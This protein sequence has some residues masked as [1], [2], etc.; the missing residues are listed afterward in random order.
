MPQGTIYVGR[1]TIWV[2]P[3]IVGVDG[4]REYCVFLYRSLACGFMAITTG[5]THTQMRAARLA[6]Q[7]AKRELEGK[8]LACWCPLNAPCHADV[9]LEIANGD[10]NR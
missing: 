4:T 7:Q 1:P 2:N 10:W 8:D 6:M 3:F 9:L 5:A